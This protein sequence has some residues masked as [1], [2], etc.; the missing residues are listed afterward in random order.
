[1]NTHEC[2]IQ[3]ERRFDAVTAADPDQIDDALGSLIRWALGEPTR[4]AT[5]ATHLL[6]P[7]MDAAAVLGLDD[8]WPSQI[9]GGLCSSG[10]RVL[11]VLV[12]CLED[13]SLDQF[14]PEVLQTFEND[15]FPVPS[16]LEGLIN[17]AVVLRLFIGAWPRYCPDARRETRSSGDGWTQTQ[18]TRTRRAPRDR[19]CGHAGSQQR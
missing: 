4:S 3:F 14:L 16:L 1:M 5:T 19:L 12:E 2:R 7:I 6:D 9:E 11:F 15:A 8:N 17:L 18:A 10:R 13:D